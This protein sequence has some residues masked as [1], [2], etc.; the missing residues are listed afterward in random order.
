VCLF[1]IGLG[2]RRVVSATDQTQREDRVAAAAVAVNLGVGHA[3]VEQAAVE[4]CLST[5]LR[6]R[7]RLTDNTQSSAQRAPLAK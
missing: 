7:L 4:H 2:Q 5:L 1:K 3:P 6:H